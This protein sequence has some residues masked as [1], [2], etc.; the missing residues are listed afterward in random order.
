MRK[1]QWDCKLY[2]SLKEYADLCCECRKVAR[3]AQEDAY[4][5]ITDFYNLPDE[6]LD[7]DYID[8]NDDMGID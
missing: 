8:D 6:E 7:N 4:R 3:A 5:E 1:C 2:A